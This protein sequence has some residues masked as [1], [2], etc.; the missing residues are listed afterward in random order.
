MSRIPISTAAR[1]LAILVLACVESH[2]ADQPE[3]R[4]TLDVQMVAVSPTKALKLIPAL[5]EPAT[6]ESAFAQ[7]QRMIEAD[8][9]EL[10]AWPMVIAP[11]LSQDRHNLDEATTLVIF[12]GD[13]APSISDS[14]VEVRYPTQ[15]NPPSE[16]TTIS[17]PGPPLRL[18]PGEI[19]TPTAFESRR[20]GV[21]LAAEAVVSERGDFIELVVHPQRTF[22]L[23]YQ[24]VR[25]AISRAGTEA[26][27]PSPQF[28]TARTI[29]R[30]TVRSGKRMLLGA[31][32]EAKPEAKV[33][34]FLMKAVA[35]R[36]GDKS[37]PP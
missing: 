6:F 1:I 9:A 25:T 10:V 24:T 8:E 14:V 11:H 18:L 3:W 30:L 27:F 33:L 37:P 2:A 5:R 26:I 12:P 17:P 29:S 23:E 35:A 7:L 15:F 20:T 32:V 22:L 31:F 21:T 16:P 34:L 28:Q 13:D 4:V 36:A 19:T